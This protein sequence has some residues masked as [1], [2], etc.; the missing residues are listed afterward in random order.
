M[1]A[2]LGCAVIDGDALARE[3]VQPGSPV[4]RKLAERFGEDICKG[5]SL[6]RSLLAERAFEST[7][8]RRDLNLITHPAINALAL[9]R[10]KALQGARA[11]AID[12]A[13]LLESELAGLCAHTLVIDAPEELRL[14]R[15]LARGGVTELAARRR[16]EAQRG[17]SFTG[18]G[19]ILITNDGS[20][21]AFG[22]AVEKAFHAMVGGSGGAAGGSAGVPAVAED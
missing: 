6:D 16:V 22:L 7:E 14:R 2:S 12:A 10:A 15:I 5:G 19:H 3:V 13:A 21:E 18:P 20:E 8:A 11:V 4:L 9:E 17:M 1:L